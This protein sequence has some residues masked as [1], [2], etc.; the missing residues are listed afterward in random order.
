MQPALIQQVFEMRL[1]LV[2]HPGGFVI[3]GAVDINAH[4]AVGILSEIE[5][6]LLDLLHLVRRPR[7]ARAKEE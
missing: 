6:K 4:R 3:G 1:Y 7:P 2:G 5:S